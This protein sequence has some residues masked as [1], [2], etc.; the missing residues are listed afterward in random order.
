M[1][2]GSVLYETELDVIRNIVQEEADVCFAGDR[3]PEE[4]ARI[5]Q[6]RV[7]MYLNES[8]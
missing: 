3:G 5:I 7:Q 4:T 1:A 2:G 6:S 8:R